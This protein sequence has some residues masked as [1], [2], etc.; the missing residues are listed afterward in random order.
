MSNLLV[1]HPDGGPVFAIV[2]GV[3]N[4][5]I[6]V[7]EGPVILRV[8][9]PQ[10]FGLEHI[11][12]R[13]GNDLAIVGCRQKSDVAKYVADLLQEGTSVL[14]Q[15]GTSWER[16]RLLA[17]RGALGIAVLQEQEIHGIGTGYSVVTAYRA[18][19]PGGQMVTR[20]LLRPAGPP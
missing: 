15:S 4:A 18:P 9:T 20:L 14:Y 17:V 11:W 13:H 5:R 19:R 2:A 3:A 6:S 7:R 1:H 10:K 16:S 8:G 12:A